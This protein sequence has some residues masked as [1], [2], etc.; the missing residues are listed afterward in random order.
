L[1]DRTLPSE[2]EFIGRPEFAVSQSVVNIISTLEQMAKRVE[3]F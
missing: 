1:Q 2:K 3:T